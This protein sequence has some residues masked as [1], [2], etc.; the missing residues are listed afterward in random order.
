MKLSFSKMQAAALCP[1]SAVIP[2]VERSYTSSATRGVVLHDFLYR[3]PTYGLEAALES[4]PEAFREQVEVIE[5]ERLPAVRPESYAGELA[6]AYNWLTQEARELGRGLERRYN[7]DAELE[8]PGTPDVVGVGVE[9]VVVGDYKT[10]FHDY[11][12]AKDVWQLRIGALAAARTYGKRW[13]TVFIWYIRPDGT[14][15]YDRARLS[16]EDLEEIA[17]Q[18]V[19]VVTRIQEAETAMRNRER[20]DYRVGEHCRRCAAFAVCPAQT[21]LAGRLASAATAPEDAFALLTGEEV[22]TPEVARR[23]VDLLPVARKLLDV[24]EESLDAHAAER[25]V[26][27]GN[28]YVYGRKAHPKETIDATKAVDV[29]KR[30]HG[31]EVALK[32]LEQPPP[33]MTKEG[34]KSALRVLVDRSPK[35]AKLR[36]GKLFDSTMAMLRDAKAATTAWSYPVMKH[37]PKDTAP[38]LAAGEGTDNAERAEGQHEAA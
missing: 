7:V 26:D 2:G 12:N 30:L 37:K 31:E 3:V 33:V 21:M 28:G 34:L 1:P 29:L 4:V 25:P 22:L 5:L 8:I 17:S 15:H 13:A 18:V 35:G 36:I 16:P 20:L 24:V 27:L 32:A 23:L 19:D 38:A 6:L 10:G 11:G 14:V 9:E